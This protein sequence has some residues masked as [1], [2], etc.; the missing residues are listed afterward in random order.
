MPDRPITVLVVDD[1]PDF[2]EQMKL[3]LEASG[4]TVVAAD[5][6]AAAAA[7]LASTQFDAA[8]C[9]LMMEHAD[10][11]FVLAHQ[12][13][14]K[15]PAIPVILVTAVAGEAG[16]PFDAASREERSWLSA[17]AVLDKPVRGEQ[18]RREL[19]RLLKVQL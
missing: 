5:S 19:S 1:N 16:I 4:I 9:D 11:G 8:V 10:S 12:I 18:L 7:L 17:D 6:G 14:R 2:L 13:K 3:A 15:D